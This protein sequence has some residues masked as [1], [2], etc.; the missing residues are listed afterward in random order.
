M[1]VGSRTE[2]VVRVGALGWQLPA[3]VERAAS[4]AD[5][6]APRTLVLPDK[7]SITV[8]PFTNLSGDPAHEYFADG[9]V[10]DI[11]MALGRLPWLFVIASASAFTYKGRAVDAR[12]V[13][14]ELGVRYV[15]RGSLRKDGDRIRIAVQLADAA[16]GGQIW[17][18]RF[19]GQIDDVFSMQDRV[20]TQVSAMIAPT[21]RSREI[22][23]ARR[24]PTDNLTAYDLFLRAHLPHRDNP[25]QIQ[26]SLRLLYKAIE[27]D[28]SFA[29][30]YGL[31]AWCYHVQTVFWS[32]LPTRSSTKPCGWPRSQPNWANRIPRRSG[33]RDAQ[34][35]AFPPTR[36]K[37][38]R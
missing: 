33:W 28:P 31:A 24:K 20:A 2:A 23:R 35:P 37:G 13:G 22:E 25:E 8:L 32:P 34:S 5:S 15:L 1:K 30:A 7:P 27:L 9:M 36:T 17:T 29:T 21:L 4:V 3:S 26:E 11:T 16:H 19:E 10:E 12:Q 6:T 18:E 14:G 38:S